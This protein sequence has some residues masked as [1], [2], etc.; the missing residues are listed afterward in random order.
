MNGDKVVVEQ[1]HYVS[2][3]II[4]TQQD[5]MKW[6]DQP[7]RHTTKSKCCGSPLLRPASSSSS[8]TDW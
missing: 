3:L 2:R 6:D 8:V 1:F 7:K 5:E 4:G